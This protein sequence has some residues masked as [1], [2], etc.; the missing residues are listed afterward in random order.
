ML[1]KCRCC[2]VSRWTDLRNKLGIAKGDQ[3]GWIMPGY[4]F[5]GFK[6]GPNDTLEFW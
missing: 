2:N 4:F 3:G 1:L 6:I 5:G